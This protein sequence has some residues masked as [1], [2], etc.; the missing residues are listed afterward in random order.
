MAPALLQGK[1]LGV[2][3]LSPSR[4]IMVPSSP[5][6]SLSAFY[7]HGCAKRRVL[8]VYCMVPR[9]IPVAVDREYALLDSRSVLCAC[10]NRSFGC[11]PFCGPIS[12]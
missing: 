8:V 3:P 6:R 10:V 9:T 1:I 2:A 4:I 5:F 12:V 7:S 11:K